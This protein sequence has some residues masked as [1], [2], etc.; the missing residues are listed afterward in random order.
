MPAETY[1]RTG[2]DVSAYVKRQFGD[3][4]G[5]QITDNDILDWIN[6]AQQ[7]IVSQNAIMRESITSDVT[8]GQDVYTYPA[9]LIQYI[10]SLH[11]DG[12]PLE[13]L[14]WQEAQ[15]YILQHKLPEGQ[16]A[17]SGVPTIWY[18]RAG[19]IT[20]WPKPQASVDDG[21]KLYYQARPADLASLA[22][23]LKVPDRYYQRV[24]DS[25]L[26]RAYQLD[27]NWEAAQFKAQ[28]FYTG[29]NML[30]QQERV[31]STNL[32]RGPTVR[33]EDL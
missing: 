13:G 15:E 11:Y 19:Q 6:I 32:Y 28:E 29:M 5:R 20:L 21:L 16:I 4:D 8:A 27:E 17:A 12:R 25:V 24:V 9:Q 31:T 1:T 7:E 10:E 30:A 33:E 22:E 2:A 23:T 18:E 14:S 3:S 26:S